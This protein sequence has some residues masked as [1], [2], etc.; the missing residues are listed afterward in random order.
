MTEKL[1]SA[2]IT[3]AG[4]KNALMRARQL[5]DL[6]WTPLTGTIPRIMRKDGERIYL[7]FNRGEEYKGIPYSSV[8]EKNTYVGS[9]ISIE[10][11]IS[12]VCNPNSFLYTR[13]LRKECNE[14]KAVP[15][16]GTV[17]SKFAQTALGIN[18]NYN[19]AHFGKIDGMRKIFSAGGYSAE[20]LERCDILL[21]AGKHTAM[22]TDILKNENGEI[23]YIEV[24][25]ETTN[26]SMRRKK[27]STEEF[28][29]HF[30]KYDVL[31]YEYLDKVPYEPSSFVNVFDEKH[32]L[33][34]RKYDVLTRRGD[35][36]NVPAGEEITLDVLTDGWEKYR[37]FKDG[38][39][40]SEAEVSKEINLGCLGP[41]DYRVLLVSGEKESRPCFFCITE[42]A[43]KA[44]SD[45][46]GKV[47]ISYSY[48]SGKPIWV[49][50]GEIGESYFSKTDAAGDEVVCYDL[51]AVKAKKVRV[52]FKNEYGIY[53]SE[54]ETF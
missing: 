24:S 5:T 21:W 49:Q 25:E 45:G 14:P 33:D 20:D 38:S 23:L 43:L 32:P 11:F 53:V 16:Y 13:D 39:L 6:S 26:P 8:Y 30:E 4:M 31:R 18:E 15:F 27:W 42:C 35:K 36:C 50:V 34:S 7:Y 41:G 29:S 48:S 12:A 37:I 22:V 17:C 51:S 9:N 52:G 19:T 54:Y 3:S 28:F 1:Y 2:P 44:E 10:T 47:R 46:E 40:F